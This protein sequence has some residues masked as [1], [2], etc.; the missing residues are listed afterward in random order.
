[1]I[2]QLHNIFRH[3]YIRIAFSLLLASVLLLSSCENPTS[4]HEAVLSVPWTEQQSIVCFGTS[5]TAGFMLNWNIIVPAGS[6][7]FQQQPDFS[8]RRTNTQQVF[9][10]ST[11]YPALLGQ[12]LRIKVFNEGIVGATCERAL[13][14]VADSVFKKNP[15]LVLLEFGANDLLQNIDAPLTEQRLNTLIDTLHS[16][17]S[18]VVLISF[19][20]PEM[21]DSIPASHFLYSRKDDARAY[22]DM[23]T[24][25]GSTRADYFVEMAMM[26]IYW[27]TEL[28]SDAIHPNRI[29]YRLMEQ[30]IESSLSATFRANKMYK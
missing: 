28:M 24:R 14:I 1:M 12:V 25:V 4:P 8:E 15:A 20:Y 17:G 11:S 5:L 26:G 16:F 18:K 9:T 13:T 22:L 23:L 19:L 3:L 7:I 29:G 21:I 10:D 6:K 2:L 30:N 27:R